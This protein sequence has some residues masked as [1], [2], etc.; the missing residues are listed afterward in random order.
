MERH[1]GA[2]Q[3][4]L[5]HVSIRVPW[6]DLGWGGVVC[7]KPS[8]NSACLILERIH[9]TRDDRAEEEVAG[10][11]W[12]E[13]R[14]DQRPACVAER[15]GF[16]RPFQMERIATHPYSEFSSAHKHLA[17]TSLPMPPHAAMA[18]PFR[19]MLLSQNQQLVDDLQ[20]GFAPEYEERALDIMGWESGTWV[21]DG[22]NQRVL[23]DTFFGALK[24]QRSLVFFYAKDVPLIDE[25]AGRRALIGVGRVTDVGPPTQYAQTEAGPLDSWLWERA[26]HH[27]VRETIDDGFLLPYHELMALG[28]ADL[29]LAELVAL[30]PQDH[31]TEFSY[32]TEHVT[33]DGA[34]A[35]LLEIQR[36]IRRVKDLVP[37]AWSRAES[38]IDD[39]LN[40]TWRLRGPCPGLASAMKA[41][42]FENGTLIAHHVAQD[43]GENED[44]WPAVERL[45]ERAAAGEDVEH[46]SENLAKAYLHHRDGTPDERV[47][48][49][50]LH[51]L[52]RFDLDA[53]QAERLYQSS[54]REKAGIDVFDD[55][56]LSNPYLIYELD[57]GQPNA[58]Q[59]LTV[60]RGVFPD[61]VIRTSHPLPVDDK[62]DDAADARR[63]RALS[64][65]ALERS[66]ERGHTLLPREQ[67]VD[68]VADLPVSPRCPLSLDLLPVV[69]EEF[70]PV[71][72][73]IDM[74][75][76]TVG[77]QLDRLVGTRE[78][79]SR[80]VNRRLTAARHD[81]DVD[82]EAELAHELADHP[83]PADPEEREA[84]ERA[85]EEKVAALEELAGSR[86]SV[87]IG[88]AGTGKTT[89]LSAFCNAEPVAAEG[90][91]LLAPTGKARVQLQTIVEHG[92]E[93]IA[94]MLLKTARFDPE[95]GRYLTDGSSPVERGSTVII[96]EASMLTEEQL[97]AVFSA[98]KS[99]K[100]Y[101]LVGDPRQ[102]P[103]IGAGRPFVDI[104][105]RLRGSSEEAGIDLDATFPRVASGHGYCELTIPRRQTGRDRYDLEL[106]R[107]FA[108]QDPG[109]GADEIW[110]LVSNDEQLETLR[111]ER[112]DTDYELQQL[113]LEVIADELDLEG[114]HDTVG[115]ELR[116][117]GS[118]HGG[119]VYFNLG[120]AEVAESWQ[121]LD[122]VRGHGHGTMNLNRFLQRH[123][124]SAT[125]ERAR[126]PFN[127]KISNPRGTDE[128]VYGDKVINLRNR[129]RK[130]WPADEA[131]GYVANGEVGVAVGMFK[132]R[133]MNFPG[134][135]KK[136]EVEFGSQ[137]GAKYAY[138]PSDFSEDGEHLELAYVITVHKSQGSQFGTTILILPNPCPLLSPEL[139]YTALTRQ[140]ERVIVLHQGD[141]A[142]LRRYADPG[143][144]ETAARMTN[145]FQAPEL[146]TVDGRYMEH[147]LVHRTTEGVLVRSKSEL[148]IANLL[149]ARGIDYE[150]EGRLVM[151]DGS[152]RLP[153]FTIHDDDLGITYYWEHL[154][155]LHDPYYRRR[156]EEKSAWYRNHGIVP[157]VEGGGESGT[158]IETR[159]TEEGTLDAQEIGALVDELFE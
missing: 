59:A 44:P 49:Q 17:P 120:A 99:V 63:T 24:P 71:I 61:D 142:D 42:R 139:L 8:Q 50:L 37:G 147:R 105:E 46:V 40:E 135:P 85:R 122:P 41:F 103:P 33:H 23:L 38:W 30:T 127:T 123:F 125:V 15:G 31:W 143:L 82:W 64:V 108:R 136:L 4:P 81:L 146:V 115:F 107:W 74:A 93:T 22:R 52:S 153:D 39:R 28:E 94:Q 98:L 65:F 77:Y 95:T 13:L 109:A 84:E 36:V 25:P 113:L 20:L 66:S 16:N 114:T 27:S 47:R 157:H 58:V 141:V 69:A 155:M 145:L 55:D 118:E 140:R 111:F 57:R 26:V 67:L 92:A 35:A 34:I 133:K 150:Y 18:V 137:P 144:S 90:V 75:D 45:L 159:D 73:P 48:I 102:L 60:D 62:V 21:Q 106:G 134:K 130:A 97:A 7:E 128:I 53:D 19:W 104:V 79:I 29:D 78:L 100:R 154:G 72:Q 112:W 14:P 149:E 126:D 152:S 156:W 56:I 124:R 70:A 116:N 10:R 68:E 89:L 119:W 3:L 80:T 86:V 91:L 1:L 43:L 151:D 76:D 117:G 54:R 9:Q 158:L 101:I 32:G 121:I 6:N 87:L 131:L 2:R 96:D 11:T 12:D 138:W 5:R 88:P 148:V 83:V 51:L 132:S 129:R 110:S